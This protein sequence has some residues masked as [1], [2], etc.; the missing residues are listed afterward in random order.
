MK[1]FDNWNKKKKELEIFEAENFYP[2]ER[3]IW[4]CTLGVNLGIE[5]DGK[6]DEFR[7]PVLVLRAFNKDMVWA[8]PLTSSCK[9]NKFYYETK[10]NG[11]KSYIMTSQIRTIS[12]K[13]LLR[14]IRVIPEKEFEEIR[15]IVKGFV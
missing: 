11:E 6:N 3:E 12:S 8:L 1:D 9:N 13:R 10:W 5:T 2:K 4:W 14:K 7:R 15:V